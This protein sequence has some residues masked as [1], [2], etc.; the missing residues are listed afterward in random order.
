MQETAGEPPPR[1]RAEGEVPHTRGLPAELVALEPDGWGPRAL[2]VVDRFGVVP[3]TACVVAVVVVG[4]LALRLFAPTPAPVEE[5]IPLVS[6]A[7]EELHPPV[8]ASLSL[9]VHVAGAISSPGVYELPGGSR[10]ID[11]VEAAGGVTADAD[12]D[13]LNLAAELT[14]GARV[15]IPVVGESA[16]P[17]VVAPEGTSDGV[18]GA[19]GPSELI[20]VNAAD[21]GE[22]E[23]LPGVGPATAAAIIDH[24]EKYGPFEVIDDLI[25]VRGIGEAKLAGLRDVAVVR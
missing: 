1:E 3:V 8:S 18:V 16:S 11:L 21:A 15:Y 24:R 7:S 4:V 12:P 9:I 19:S 20:D 6:E 25:E 22:L 13:R 10:V 14:D 5:T 17:D 23:T 2:R